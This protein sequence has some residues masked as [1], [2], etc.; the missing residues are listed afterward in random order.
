M[1]DS[2]FTDHNGGSMISTC[3][4][5]AKGT[6]A[7]LNLSNC[8]RRC[9]SNWRFESHRKEE[10][11]EIWDNK[12]RTVP[13]TKSVDA[14]SVTSERAPNNGQRAYLC[15][16]LKED[17][18]ACE[19]SRQAPDPPHEKAMSSFLIAMIRNN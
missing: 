7:E 5:N 2:T 13:K 3:K 19:G 8:A 11:T 18:L 10:S 6:S 17:S 4:N 1:R 12:Y 16:A 9:N 14:A 15:T